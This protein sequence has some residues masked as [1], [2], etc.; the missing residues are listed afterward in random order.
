MTISNDSSSRASL[1]KRKGGV[2]P[3]TDDINAINELL[4][5]EIPDALQP[6]LDNNKLSPTKQKK[7]DDKNKRA[8]K[9]LKAL[10]ARTKA[11]VYALVY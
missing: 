11:E 7:Y 6:E 2:I 8:V 3:K 5:E 9:R 4:E 1:N 10:L